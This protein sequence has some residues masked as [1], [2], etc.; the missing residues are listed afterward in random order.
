MLRLII[1]NGTNSG[2]QLHLE[3]GWL[4]LGR[5]EESVV[6]FVEPSVSTRHA[7][8]STEHNEFFVLDQGSTNGTFLNG[9]RVQTARLSHGDVIELGPF[10][11]RLHVVIDTHAPVSG[12]A[13][14]AETR[15][16][17]IDTARARSAQTAQWTIREA[18]QTMGL[19]NPHHDSGDAPPAPGVALLA[20]LSAVMGVIVLAL[21]F[22]NFGLS[23]SIRAGLMAFIPAMIYLG[24]FLW[25]D[26]YDPEPV[27]TLAFAFAWGA[28]VAVLVSSVF[29]EIFK[30]AFNDFLTGIISAPL[31]EE[32]SKGVGVLLIALLF[33]RDFDSV[34]DGIVY[35]GVVALGFAT[36]ENVD[37][38]GDSF[39]SGGP[40]KLVGTF[41][42]RGILS[43]FSHVLF[44]C[45]TGI[46]CG[47]AR[48]THRKFLRFAAPLAGYFAAMFLHALW[49][50]LASFNPTLFWMGYLLLE[51]PL[52]IAFVCVIGIL[53]R[54][55]GQILKRTL[56]TEVERGLIS[57]EQLK[58][59]ISV[60]R[61]SNWVMSAFGHNERF[62]ARRQFL[63][64]VAKLG[65]CHWHNSRAAEASGSTGSFS[66]IPRL[67]AEIFRLR[68]QIG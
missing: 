54:R 51:F 35:A 67:Q 32:G 16:Q 5:G 6:R 50:G 39:V 31:I 22:L 38:Y 64:A 27:R 57:D 26:R 46:G 23:V 30:H 63:R 3:Q 7:I 65:L 37:Y 66:M 12:A 29:N 62:T 11:P 59:A 28:G 20:I 43:P 47:I 60:F 15:P 45:M 68:D 36:M 61:R 10:G 21:T 13:A 33:R 18:A 49:N 2:V 58:I 55:E 34:V 41:I 42:V 19:Y 52:F 24:M 1:Q 48:E 9:E 53:V 8:I 25:L 14:D 44:T 56:A 40:D 17:F 4:V